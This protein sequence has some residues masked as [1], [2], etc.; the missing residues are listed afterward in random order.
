MNTIRTMR[1]S[2]KQG[3][4]NGATP[5]LN[6]KIVEAE[7]RGQKIKKKLAIDAANYQ[8][9]C[10]AAFTDST[11]QVTAAVVTEEIRRVLCW[12]IKKNTRSGSPGG[13]KDSHN[14]TAARAKNAGCTAS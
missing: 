8:P 1:E 14:G 11:S 12:P 10:C 3:F 13:E 5:P 6:Y 7:R 9:T 4:W 2:A